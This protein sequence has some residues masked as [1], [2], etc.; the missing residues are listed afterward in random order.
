MTNS[1]IFGA[2]D[3][4]TNERPS[5]QVFSHMLVFIAYFAASKSSTRTRWPQSS[6]TKET[7][8][9]IVGWFRKSIL[10]FL[11]QAA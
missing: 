6:L 1:K 7:T 2:S 9:E 3:P 4:P 11:P 10:H 8:L 5:Y